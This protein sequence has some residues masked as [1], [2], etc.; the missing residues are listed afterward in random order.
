MIAVS[1]SENVIHNFQSCIS[2]WQREDGPEPVRLTDSERRTIAA[3]E[4]YYSRTTGN[5][6]TLIGSKSQAVR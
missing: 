1:S 3:S 6:T 2:L 4:Q 5:D